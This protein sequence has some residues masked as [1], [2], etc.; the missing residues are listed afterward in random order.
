MITIGAMMLLSLLILRVNS[1]QVV[2]Y[3]T[4]TD[5]KLGIIGITIANAYVDYAKKRVFDRII[6]DTTQTYGGTLAELTPAGSLG[7]E[8]EIYPNFNDFDD[9]NLYDPALGR[10]QIIPDSTS[11]TNSTIPGLYTKFYI[12]SHV[13][14]VD[15]TDFK[16]KK[17]IPTWFKRIDVSVWTDGMTDTIKCSSI[18]TS[19]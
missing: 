17:G 15:Q 12:A 14:Y 6:A 8:S 5:S 16:T 2:S 10:Y 4:I 1:S 7:P 11:L 13:Y 9:F 18:S 19:W 3:N